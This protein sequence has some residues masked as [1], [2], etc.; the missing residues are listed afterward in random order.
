[1]LAVGIIGYF[2][3]PHREL[4][5]FVGLALLIWVPAV[6]CPSALTVAA[7][8]LAEAS[9]IIYLTHY[10]VYP[11]FGEHRLL[12]VIAALL[13]GILLTRLLI[14]A[15]RRIRVRRDSRRHLSDG[16]SRSAMRPSCATVAAISPFAP[17]RLPVI[18]PRPRAAAGDLVSSRFQ[19]SA[20]TGR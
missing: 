18:T 8:V 9:L 5:V 20:R 3:N 7:G 6:R 13:T 17:T 14:M 2:G 4:L 15:R 19:R 16:F 10:Q 11:L 12:G 1:M